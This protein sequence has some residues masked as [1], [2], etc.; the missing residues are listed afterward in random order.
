MDLEKVATD[1]TL[2]QLAADPLLDILHNVFNLENFRGK[3][4]QVIENIMDNKDIL[5]VI[6][7]GGGK[8]LCYW[9][10]GIATSGV[11]VVITP[12]LAIAK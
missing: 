1:K 6:P 7:T 8:S 11:T 9:V 10:P 3:Q 4:R 5:A 2:P 12:L